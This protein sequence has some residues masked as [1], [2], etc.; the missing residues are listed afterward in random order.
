MEYELQVDIDTQS[1][2]GHTQ[3]LLVRL[4]TDVCREVLLLGKERPVLRHVNLRKKKRP[5]VG[6][7]RAL[8]AVGA[9][10]RCVFEAFSARS[11]SQVAVSARYAAF[12]LQQ[13]ETSELGAELLLSSLKRLLLILA[14][15]LWR[16]KKPREA[17]MTKTIPY[18]IL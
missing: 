14:Q 6:T 8:E 4:S 11:G 7:S 16:S 17:L 12:R 13:E 10:M 3:W 9:R 2:Q 5:D 1:P 15:A 18:Y